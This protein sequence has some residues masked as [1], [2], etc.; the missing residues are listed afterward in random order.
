MQNDGL[1]KSPK[2]QADMLKDDNTEKCYYNYFVMKWNSK[3]EL[4]RHEIWEARC[5]GQAG[6]TK[7]KEQTL[8]LRHKEARFLSLYN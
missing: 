2:R 3:S 6:G 5:R 8:S 4:G 1:V 7:E